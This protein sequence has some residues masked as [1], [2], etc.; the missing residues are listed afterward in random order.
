M[1]DRLDDLDTVRFTKP[2]HQVTNQPP[3]LV[4]YNAWTGDAIL[5]DAVQREGGAGSRAARPISASW[6]AASGCR[7][8]PRRRTGSRRSCARTTPLATAS[9]RSTTTPPTTS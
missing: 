2:T 1:N 7:C 8:S 6:S 3:P 5:R 9:T 4:G